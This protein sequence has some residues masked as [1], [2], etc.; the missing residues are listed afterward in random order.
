MYWCAASTQD[1]NG[2]KMK[3]KWKILPLH[4]QNIHVN[5]ASPHYKKCGHGNLQGDAKNRLWITPGKYKSIA[6]DKGY[7]I[8]HSFFSTYLY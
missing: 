7:P 4:I 1:G 2:E 6:I 5:P 3:E 8:M